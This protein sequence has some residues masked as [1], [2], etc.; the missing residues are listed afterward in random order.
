ME[1]ERQEIKKLIKFYSAFY[2]EASS[3]HI[4]AIKVKGNFAVKQISEKLASHGFDIRALMSP[5]VRQGHEILRLCMHAFNTK[6][7]IEDFINILKN[8]GWKFR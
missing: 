2:Q 8:Q 3:T 5:T 4:Q 1:K 7:Q 6:H